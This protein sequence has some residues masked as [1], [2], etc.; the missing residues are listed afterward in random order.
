[1]TLDMARSNLPFSTSIYLGTLALMAHTNSSTV[2]RLNF[3]YAEMLKYAQTNYQDDLVKWPIT[4]STIFI[5]YIF[6]NLIRIIPTL[7][8]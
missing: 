7:D 1:M 6:T 5:Q 3:F 4:T 2:A 8:D